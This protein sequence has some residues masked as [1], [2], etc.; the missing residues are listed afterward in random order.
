MTVFGVSGEFIGSSVARHFNSVP[1]M[2]SDTNVSD[3]VLAMVAS[4]ARF[5]FT[6]TTAAQFII[7]P[8]TV[9]LPN[10]H[11]GYWTGRFISQHASAGIQL[12]SEFNPSRFSF[13]GYIPSLGTD[14]NISYSSNDGIHYT[15]TDF[16]DSSYQPLTNPV[17][18]SDPIKLAPSSPWD[19]DIGYFMIVENTDIRRYI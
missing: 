2:Q 6:E 4:V 18:M 11:S 9:E 8:E 1:D 10:Q 19:N 7:F 15:R 12:W 16:Y 17:D 3:G 13:Y 5:N 14:Y